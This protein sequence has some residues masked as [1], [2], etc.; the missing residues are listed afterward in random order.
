LKRIKFSILFTL[1]VIQL[2]AQTTVHL[3]V[4]DTNHNFFVPYTLGSTY[5]WQVQGSSSIAT[6]TS[7]NGTEHIKIDLNNIGVFKL[8]VA[9][10]DVNG[11]NG[12]DSIL[13]E[14]H[15]VPSPIV[16]AIGPTDFCEGDNVR[17]EV[18]SLYTSILWNNGQT[19]IFTYAFTSGN[20]FA[21]VTDSNGCTNSSLPIMVNM[22]PNPEANFTFSANCL[23]GPTLF[24]DISTIASDSLVNFIWDFGDGKIGIGNQTLHNYQNTGAH[25]VRLLV[26]SSFGCKD[27]IRKNIQILPK[28][29]VDFSYNPLSTTIVNPII[30]FTN[31]SINAL[32]TIWDFDDSTFSFL[33]SPTHE[34]TYPG[35]FDVMLVAADSNNCTDSIEHTINIYYELLLYTPNSFTPNGDGDND[36]FLPMGFR[37]NKYQN[38]QFTIFN[39]WGEIIFSTDKTAEGW[40]GANAKA[41][42]FT[43]VVTLT[44]EMGA[45]RKKVGQVMLIR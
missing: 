1:A 36:V 24:T 27:S 2:S 15:P 7:G 33:E 13:V 10:T 6:I 14:V 32:P 43:W 25:F 34:F 30:D 3:C 42:V 38:Y 28:P 39:K 8:V 21:T 26:I 40:D 18:D 12:S 11:C 20:Y 23:E 37:M 5:Q 45:I 9:E 17:L 41:D 16:T 29:I 31:Q 44:D 4:G 19:T 35:S 22:H